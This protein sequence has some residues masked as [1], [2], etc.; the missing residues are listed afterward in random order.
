MMLKIDQLRRIPLFSDLEEVELELILKSSHVVTYPPRNIIFHEGDP[1]GCLYI[2]LSGG[3]KIVLLGEKGK[4][5]ILG[6]V[7]PEDF[8]GV[9]S[10]L[11]D[12]PRCSTAISLDKTILFQLSKDKLRGLFQKHSE[13]AVKILFRVGKWLRDADGQIRSMGMDDIY[14][15][16]VYGL[17]KFKDP[18]T[19]RKDGQIVIESRPSVQELA[20][21]IG[22][23][24]ETVSR[25][26]KIMKEN[27]FLRETNHSY[28]LE[29]RILTK[30]STL[31]RDFKSSCSSLAS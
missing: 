3:V 10:L 5:I 26:L 28:V 7:K 12:G 9:L 17:L 13:M 1:G 6:T 21:R 18:S 14:G 27:N 20:D 15:R 2:V 4:Q 24:R 8:F 31:I 11:D 29:H 23:S 22:S 25:A 30:Y 16:I 19:L